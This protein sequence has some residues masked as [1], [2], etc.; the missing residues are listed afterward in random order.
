M[1]APVGRRA[2]T[3]PG[4]HYVGRVGA[5]PTVLTSRSAI[6]TATWL[7]ATLALLVAACTSPDSSTLSDRADLT[8]HTDRPIGSFDRRLLGTNVP[9]WVGPELLADDGFRAATVALG[10]PLIRLP[11]GSWSNHYDWLAC[12]TGDESSCYWPWA[13]RPTDFL[14]FLEATG[15][16][17]M[18]TVSINGTAEE[19]AA[20]VAFFNGAVD[21]DRAIGTDRNGRDWA[22]VG[23]WARLRAG[24]G[25][26]DPHRIDLWEVGNEVYGAVAGTGPGCAPFGWEEVWTC[27]GT[28]Y[29]TGTDDHDGFLRFRDAM[30][31]V[32]DEI[33]VGIVG[34][35]SATEWGGWGD[36]VI[37]T[38][39]DQ[40]DFYVV[41][42]YAT[43]GSIRLEGAMAAPGRDWPRIVADVEDAYQR[44]GLADRPP[45]AVTEHNLVSFIEGDADRNM[46][47]VL[48]ALYLAETIGQLALN[49]IPIANQWNLAN[50]RHENGT[51]YGLIDI[52]TGDPSPA[53]HALA[54]WARF[55]DELVETSLAGRAETSALRSYAAM[56]G[57]AVTLLV[58]NPSAEPVPA[59]LGIDPAVGPSDVTLDV[60][61]ARTTD[62]TEVTV[63][64]L[65]GANVPPADPIDLGVVLDEFEHE[66]PGTSISLLRWQP[67]R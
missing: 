32:D 36:D 49:G 42:H 27:D 3:R 60:V 52:E 31:A 62:A 37:S 18:W 24:H 57:T 2:G 55:G 25:N 65:D 6:T 9:A 53:Y 50:G 64:G 23:H 11:G 58:V 17:G 38:A 26:P 20:L 12:E 7:L 54:T 5:R 8:V 47:T 35:E 39:A 16:E 40:F 14:E 22:T 44:H 15:T 19:A 61:Q 13:A 66:F 41:H 63:N 56:D 4:D 43:D 59:T 46:T 48:N 29:V 1:A 45:I 21:D 67:D 33:E 28:E 34:T 51:D 30:V 10:T